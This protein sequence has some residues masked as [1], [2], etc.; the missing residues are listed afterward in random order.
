MAEPS[1]AVVDQ[2]IGWMV[3]L[4]SG[5]ASPQDW[6][7]WKHWQSAQPEHAQAW[8][9]VQSIQS[10][11]AALPPQASANTFERA[12]RDVSRRQAMRLLGLAGVV[13]GAGTLGWLNLAGNPGAALMADLRTGTGERRRV[14]LDD[15]STLWLDTATAVNLNFDAGARRLTLL[16][17]RILVDTGS[18]ANAAAKRPFSVHTAQGRALALGTRFLVRQDDAATLVQVFEHAVELRSAG[19]EA[20][21]GKPSVRIIRQG[22]QAWLDQDGPGQPRALDTDADAWTDGV[23]VARDMRLADFCAE[24]ARYRSGRLAC[25]ARVAELRISGV[26]NLHDTDLALDL[27]ARTLPVRTRQLTRYWVTLQ[28]R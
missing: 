22:E 1:T 23:L 19:A 16:R 13:G 10:R 17:G 18:D 25:D 28:P 5:E 27:V 20:D 14:A 6:D 2:A 4:Q 24:L 12:R 21:A 9:R 26:F 15:G 3:R 7:A 8:E 11:L